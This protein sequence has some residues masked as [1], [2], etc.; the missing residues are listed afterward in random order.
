MFN[1]D[2]KEE[3][4]MKKAI[5]EILKGNI[6]TLIDCIRD[7]PEIINQFNQKFDVAKASIRKNEYP[8][9]I[10]IKIH[11]E[12]KDY[13]ELSKEPVYGFLEYELK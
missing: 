13:Y 8:K 6:E 9:K 2:S 4:N 10:Y 11:D 1:Y 5:Q 12:I 3:K 7:N